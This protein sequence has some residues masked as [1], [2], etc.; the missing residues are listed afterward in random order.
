M[1]GFFRA[2]IFEPSSIPLE[3]RSIVGDVRPWG[4]MAALELVA[5]E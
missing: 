3:K 5:D 4:M 1:R 2:L